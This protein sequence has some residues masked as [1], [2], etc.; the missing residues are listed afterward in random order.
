MVTILHC[1]P[2]TELTY[3]ARLLN[4]GFAVD[5]KVRPVGQ[6][7]GPLPVVTAHHRPAGVRPAPSW[8]P[9][10]QP[11]QPMLPAVPIA[12]GVGALLLGALA[13]WGIVRL[14]RRSGRA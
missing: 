8:H 13:G 1:V 4:W 11:K 5:G 2:L 9:V 6:L 14:S 12:A 7:V 3:A 10:A